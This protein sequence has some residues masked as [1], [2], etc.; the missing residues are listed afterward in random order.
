MQKQKELHAQ[1]K[2]GVRDVYATRIQSKF[3]GDSARR[4]TRERMAK[5]ELSR[6]A[7]L[8]R[9]VD[10]I[11][12]VIREQ[13]KANRSLYGRALVDA[14]ETFRIMDKDGSGYLDAQEFSGA[15]HRMGLGL[16]EEQVADVLSLVDK[17]GDGEI[18]YD[19]YIA[20]LAKGDP[21]L[22]QS[23]DAQVPPTGQVRR[24]CPVP[25]LSQAGVGQ[26]LERK[27]RERKEQRRAKKRAAKAKS[28]A[29][30][31]GHALGQHIMK[32]QV[33]TKHLSSK[34]D[35]RLVLTDGCGW[36]SQDRI[37]LLEEE[38]AERELKERVY[39]SEESAAAVQIQS[40]F[41][42]RQV[43]KSLTAIRERFRQAQVADAM[44]QMFMRPS[45]QS[46]REGDDSADYSLIQPEGWVPH[47]RS[48]EDDVSRTILVASFGFP[49]V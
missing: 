5:I 33:H 26:V 22:A 34:P 38:Q 11:F 14:A 8:Q 43:Q 46:P 47:D 2:K 44:A 13:M 7:K 31:Q 27:R 20:L 25:A 16:T 18:D 23:E 39:T 24:A 41:R 49:N 17:D 9:T 3:R 19:E 28:A 32:P 45:E 35:R 40:R 10:N 21:E 36:C 30:T 42:G 12:R 1:S 48:F 37:R 4:S 15:L 6:D 29:A